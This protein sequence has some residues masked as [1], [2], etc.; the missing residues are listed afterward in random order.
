MSAS[1]LQPLSLPIKNTENIASS[2]SPLQQK[3]DYFT[4]INAPMDRKLSLETHRS[5]SSGYISPVTPRSINS[6]NPFLNQGLFL[7]SQPTPIVVVD[8]NPFRSLSINSDSS[9]AIYNMPMKS[10]MYDTVALNTPPISSTAPLIFT[11]PFM[12]SNIS[13]NHHR[14]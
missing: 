5:M 14:M 13:Q 9:G 6:S 1:T 4:Q 2:P 11:N 12:Q 3:E 8:T 10:P 7:H